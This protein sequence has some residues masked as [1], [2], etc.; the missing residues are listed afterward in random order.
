MPFWDK[1]DARLPD[2]IRDASQDDLVAAVRFFK[3]NKDKLATLNSELETT[4]TTLSNVETKFGETQQALA[5]LQAA[6]AQRQQEQAKQA[7]SNQQPAQP[8]DWWQDPQAAY[9]SQ[10]A[11]RDQFMFDTKAQVAQMK[12]EHEVLVEPGR[13]GDDPKI[14]K[15]YRNE[16]ADLMK[17][18]PLQNQANL[19][20]WKN[21]YLLIKGLHLDEI[22]EAR[23]KD[24]REFFGETPKPAL[25]ADARQ[26]DEVSEADRKAAER[27]GLKPEQ[28]LEARKNMTFAP[29]QRT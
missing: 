3:E 13:F 29:E 26:Q 20:A 15:K 27:Y 11:V 28:V 8:P 17:R 23:Q 18:E 9:N 2:E 16:V 24:D 4:K 5:Q 6:E 21:A 10:Q 19:Q 14:Y 1:N 12:F 22:N 25:P 7:S